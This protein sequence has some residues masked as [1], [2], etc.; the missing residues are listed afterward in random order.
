MSIATLDF[1]TYIHLLNGYVADYIAKGHDLHSA[2]ALAKAEMDG[3]FRCE[4]FA[5]DAAD[6]KEGLCS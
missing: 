2:R 5:Q 6:D 1:G 4:D 3:A